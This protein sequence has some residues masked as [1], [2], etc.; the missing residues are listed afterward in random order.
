LF[1]EGSTVVNVYLLCTYTKTTETD[2][3]RLKYIYLPLLGKDVL[4]SETYST[5]PSPGK[6]VAN[7]IH[8]TCKNQRRHFFENFCFD[9]VSSGLRALRAQGF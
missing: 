9:A 3:K 5:Y 2:R 8:F 7:E 4:I 6:L 1:L